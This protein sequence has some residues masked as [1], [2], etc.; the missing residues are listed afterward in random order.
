MT[1]QTSQYPPNTN[2]CPH[3]GK[4]VANSFD[5]H[6][7]IVHPDKRAKPQEYLDW[8]EIQRAQNAKKKSKKKS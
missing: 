7:A 3:C 4:K 2:P 5:V 8:Q 1:W 6:E